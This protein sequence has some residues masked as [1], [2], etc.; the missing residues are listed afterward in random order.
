MSKCFDVQK[1][2]L[3]K[4]GEVNVKIDLPA[5]DNYIDSAVDMTFPASVKNDLSKF[6]NSENEQ[7]MDWHNIN[8]HLNSPTSKAPHSPVTIV[9]DTGSPA[10]PTMILVEGMPY[11]Y[12][13]IVEMGDALAK[14]RRERMFP[15]TIAPGYNVKAIIDDFEA[16]ERL[17][18]ARAGTKDARDDAFHP[19]IC[20]LYIE[21][22][23]KIQDRD[24]TYGE[25]AAESNV[26]ARL[27]GLA[28]GTGAET[29][30]YNL[31]R[32]AMNSVLRLNNL[33][34]D[35]DNNI[36]DA[37]ATRVINDIR[38]TV[39]GQATHGT[40]GVNEQNMGAVMEEVFSAIEH[41]LGDQAS[42]FNTI[43]DTQRAQLNNM[44]NVTNAQNAQV[45]AIAGHVN[46]IDNHVHA[47]G[48][49]VN[50]M[51]TLLNST[52]GNLT[53]LTTNVST[54]Q[55]VLNMIPQMVTKSVQDMLP[56]VIGSAFEAAISNELVARLQA[57]TSAM[58]EARSH[59]ETGNQA[60]E[61]R[62]RNWFRIF[63]KGFGRHTKNP[64]H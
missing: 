8:S 30:M 58:N 21:I 34:H 5:R 56:D 27:S 29:G 38:A 45:N 48:N 44:N 10:S 1:K 31:M 24:L 40:N 16:L 59:A 9:N 7:E 51:G 47:M 25:V 3:A 64:T 19:E 32:H 36:V 26:R 17:N 61:K 55:A 33:T 53:T 12:S 62:G 23:R 37:V 39:Q 63:K 4:L 2:T 22:Q 52:N 46:A 49:N 11:A 60:R 28:N 18:A 54:L 43:T 57:F 42:N 6:D 15:S 14:A 50:A 13:R 20:R 35:S 41:A